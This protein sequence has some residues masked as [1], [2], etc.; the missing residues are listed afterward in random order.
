M[1]R[2]LQ[3][4]VRRI[5]RDRCEYCHL[6]GSVPRLKHVVDHIVARQHGGQSDL[7]NLALSCG[8][9]NLCKGPNIAGG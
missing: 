3:R 5:A 4:E 7:D 1:D 6:P 8:R 2:A 9:C